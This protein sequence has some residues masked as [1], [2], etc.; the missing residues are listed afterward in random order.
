VR[1]ALLICLL[2]GCAGAPPLPTEFELAHEKEAR[3][4]DDGALLLYRTVR[5]ACERPGAQPLPKDDCALALVREA[6][7]HEKHHRWREAFETWKK[8][9]ERSSDRRKSSRALVRAAVV[10]ADELGD[11]PTAE[12]L[13]WRTV[14]KWPDE[15]PADDAL[16]LAVRLGKKRDARALIKTLDA[17]YPR[18]ATLDLGDNVLWERAELLR[19]TSTRPA[20]TSSATTRWEARS[21]QRRRAARSAMPRPLATLCRTRHWVAETSTGAAT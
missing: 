16:A 18:V 9:P 19:T 3:G 11:E 1:R 17:L 7:F 4:D 13:A 5:A 15:V 20:C 10:A 14:E 6:Q 12:A 2:G 8:V 21:L